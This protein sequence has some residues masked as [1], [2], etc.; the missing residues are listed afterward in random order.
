[1]ETILIYLAKVN[2]ALTVFYILFLILFRRDTFFAFKRY[3]FLFAIA[4]SLI[5]PFLTI[6]GLPTLHLF[7]NL[8][9]NTAQVVIGNPSATYIVADASDKT[10]TK[11]FDWELSLC[12][13]ILA[14]IAF[15]TVRLLWQLSSIFRIKRKSVKQLMNGIIVYQ[16]PD[17]IT[18]FSFFH[19]I[20]LHRESHTEKELAHILL[21]EQI[22]KDQGHS[23]DIL[24][25]ELLCTFFW[26]NPFVWLMKKDMAINLECLADNGVLRQGINSREYQYHLLRLTYHETAIQIVNNFN[27]SQLKQRI[28]MMN[29]SKSPRGKLA[30]MLIVLPFIL[31]M[32]SVNSSF[33]RNENQKNTN[34]NI[35]Q[36]KQKKT[37]S[38]EPV[39]VAVQKMPEFVGGMDALM[40][41]LSTNIQYPAEA[42][43]KGIHGTVII[44]FIVEKD[45]SLSDVQVVRSVDQSLDNE[46]VKVIKK[47][48]K[49]IPGQQNGKNVRVKFTLPVEFKLNKEVQ[50][51]INEVGNGS[52][53]SGQS[54]NS[55]MEQKSV[56][57]EE[58]FDIADTP[59]VFP[60]GQEALFKYLASN[61]KY[62]AEAMNAKKEGIVVCK[63][64][65]QKDGNITDVKVIRSVDPLLDK[66]AVRVIEAMPKWEP[67]FKGNKPVNVGFTI[68]ISFKLDMA[69]KSST[70]N[71]AT[72]EKPSK[73]DAEYFNFISRNIKY[74][75]SAQEKGITGLIKANY[76]VSEKGEISNVKILQGVDPSLE[77]EVMRVIK[78]LPPDIALVKTGGKANA[79]V[80]FSVYFHLLGKESTPT[81]YPQSDFVVVGYKKE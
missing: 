79:D 45:G 78:A 66:E 65:V 31:L 26:Y 71:N 81:N 69:E 37:N 59:P 73:A 14:G 58:V 10:A 13:V 63:F 49:W 33:A 9:E 40:N 54:D 47:M 64:V 51:T 18:P 55:Y 15:G 1:M 61:I 5:Y 32:I 74:P 67:G 16:Y 60:G 39:F 17:E 25:A 19:W 38:N 34:E 72:Q 29:K 57:G 53:N 21:H 7:G 27:V 68:P 8:H 3:F 4:F 56:N 35:L 44:S 30:K 2:I 28:I 12:C 70:N 41:Y 42:Q 48:P 52:T 50:I 6:N 36:D 62:P 22:H 77:A 46:A 43:Q 20:F 11:T 80:D 76:S 23:A 75:V 24:L